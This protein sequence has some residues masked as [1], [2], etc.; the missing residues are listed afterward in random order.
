MT[1]DHPMQPTPEQLREWREQARNAADHY[2]IDYTA[3]VAYAAYAAGADAQLEA[4]VKWTEER[5]FQLSYGTLPADDLRRA[6]RPKPPS[7]AELAAKD[8]AILRRD[9]ERCALR[10]SSTRIEAAL[11]RLA[12]LEGEA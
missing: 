7:L 11:K 4:D 12:E 9:A 8:L 5:T 2:C 6:M 1:N 10:F 3:R